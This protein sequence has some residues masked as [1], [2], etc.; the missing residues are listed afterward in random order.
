MSNLYLLRA[1]LIT[2]E[3]FLLEHPLGS[4]QRS[5]RMVQVVN[6]FSAI[7]CP[8]ERLLEGYIW[9]PAVDVQY[10]ID[11]SKTV[12]TLAIVKSSGSFAADIEMVKTEIPLLVNTVGIRR[13]AKL[14]PGGGG[15]GKKGFY[16]EV[17]TA[18]A[19]ALANFEAAKLAGIGNDDFVEF[20][21]PRN[22]KMK[23]CK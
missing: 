6:R 17:G 22:F 10:E 14:R 13:A 7:H 9:E 3:S 1:D 18:K 19:Q 11:L 20:C 12:P 8:G 2:V 16:L 4:L 21:V 23:H 5:D 15:K